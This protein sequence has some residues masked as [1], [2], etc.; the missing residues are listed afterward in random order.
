MRI[1]KDEYICLQVES[2]S[3]LMNHK[4]LSWHRCWDVFAACSHSSNFPHKMAATT[5]LVRS[6]V[7]ET[8]QNIQIIYNF[9]L[10][11]YGLA[12]FPFVKIPVKNLVLLQKRE[13]N[14]HAVCKTVDKR[15]IYFLKCS[16]WNCDV[17]DLKFWIPC[18]SKKLIW[19]IVNGGGQSDFYITDVF[20]SEASKQILSNNFWTIDEEIHDS[21]DI[22]LLLFH[23]IHVLWTLYSFPISLFCHIVPY[24]LFFC[25]DPWTIFPHVRL[26]PKPHT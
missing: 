19:L 22:S 1:L 12:H 16:C 21:L 17:R 18:R 13:R 24:S 25:F 10:F 3:V 8:G 2:F 14:S 23:L 11:L 6:Q 5:A 4:A 20:F 26:T 9:P 7:C 15:V